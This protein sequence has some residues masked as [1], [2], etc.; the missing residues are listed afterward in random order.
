MGLCLP[1][2]RWDSR[3]GEPILADSSPCDAV[4]ELS[5]SST[6]HPQAPNSSVGFT[7]RALLL[8]VWN[9]SGFPHLL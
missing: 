3:S 7:L 4:W 6:G 5:G 1:R 9:H 8:P 2:L